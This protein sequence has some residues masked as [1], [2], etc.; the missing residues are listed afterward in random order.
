MWQV[1]IKRKEEDE[2]KIVADEEVLSVDERTNERTADISL[3]NTNTVVLR[4]HHQ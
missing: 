2:G 3:T 4:R 1:G